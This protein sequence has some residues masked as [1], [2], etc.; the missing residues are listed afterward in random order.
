MRRLGM[1]PKERRRACQ[2]AQ[3]EEQGLN[4]RNKRATVPSR[5][6]CRKSEI[7][8][9]RRAATKM[10]PVQKATKGV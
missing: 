3:I 7:E 9:C 5:E 10:G 2:R 8:A 6:E 4:E 1:K